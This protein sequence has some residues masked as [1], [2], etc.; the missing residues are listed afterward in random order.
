M[1]GLGLGSAI[2]IAFYIAL[3]IELVHLVGISVVRGYHYRT[4]HR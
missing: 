1:G 3:F 2:F 4:I